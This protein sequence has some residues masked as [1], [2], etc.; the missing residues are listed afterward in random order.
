M[1]MESI[2]SESYPDYVN[3]V[4]IKMGDL[5]RKLDPPLEPIEETKNNRNDYNCLSPRIPISPTFLQ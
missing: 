3:V 5:A 1:D 4:G 2:R